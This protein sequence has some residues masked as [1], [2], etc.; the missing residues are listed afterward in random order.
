MQQ[1]AGAHP[2]TLNPRLLQMEYAVRGQLVLRAEAHAKALAAGQKMEF[3]DLVFCNIGNPQ[4]VGQAP[5]TFFRQ[6]QALV[7]CPSLL[8]EPAVLAAMPKDAVAR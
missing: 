8:E 5:I 3:E 6:V 7:M 2:D 4:S 1:Y